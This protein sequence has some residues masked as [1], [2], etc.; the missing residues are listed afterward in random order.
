MK[1]N[2]Y[3]RRMRMRM[4][5]RMRVPCGTFTVNLLE[6]RRRLLVERIDDRRARCDLS[7]SWQS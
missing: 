1:G 5:M 3:Y 4:R 2:A 6:R 7:R